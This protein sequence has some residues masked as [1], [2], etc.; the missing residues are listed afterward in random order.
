MT[1]TAG[2][3]ML[4]LTENFLVDV[5]PPVHAWLVENSCVCIAT[6]YANA[7]STDSKATSVS[8]SLCRDHHSG[9][10]CSTVFFPLFLNVGCPS[11]NN[12]VHLFGYLYWLY[13]VGGWDNN[14]VNLG[15]YEEGLSHCT[16]YK[17]KKIS[18]RNPGKVW[19][20]W[21]DVNLFW[22]VFTPCINMRPKKCNHHLDANLVAGVK[23]MVLQMLFDWLDLTLLLYMQI[24]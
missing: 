13:T 21:L 5:F 10:L 24:K 12:P 23:K 6:V 17:T 4:P 9:S 19:L 18:W 15:V 7:K 8:F 1:T 16:F 14:V 2:D 20:K 22:N 3:H 11:W